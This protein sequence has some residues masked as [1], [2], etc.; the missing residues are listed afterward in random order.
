MFVVRVAVSLKFIK[1]LLIKFNFTETLDFKKKD[2]VID[3][4]NS[5]IN[6]S[7]VPSNAYNV[8]TAPAG[9]LA[10]FQD[11]TSLC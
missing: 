11:G 3:E 6:L 5:E 7:E 10:V 2:N 9:I 1:L 8:S 4:I